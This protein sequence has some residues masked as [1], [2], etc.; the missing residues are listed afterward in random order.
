ML[1]REFPDAGIHVATDVAS[2]AAALTL[3]DIDAIVLEPDLQWVDG[4]ALRALVAGHWP[5]AALIVFGHEQDLLSRCLAPGVVADALARKSSAGFMALPDILRG[6][7]ARRGPAGTK[8]PGGDWLADLPVPACLVADDG[9]VVDANPEFLAVAGAVAAP[10]SAFIGLLDSAAV[11]TWQQFRAGSDATCSLGLRLAGTDA[12]ARLRRRREAGGF[13]VSLADSRAPAAAPAPADSGRA[14]AEEISDVAMMFSHDLKAPVQQIV[15]LLHQAEVDSTGN[16]DRQRL[17]GKAGDC[18]R[19]VGE[20]IDA[21]LQYL[22]VTTRTGA[23]GLVDLNE[24]LASALATL[25]PV[26]DDTD[27]DIIAHPLPSIVGDEIQLQHLFQN[28]LGN[29]IKFHGQE[30]P[31]VEITA[32][33]SGRHW[34]ISFMDNGIGIDAAFRDSVFEMGRRLHT[35]DEYPGTGIGLTLCRRIAARHGGSIHIDAGRDGGTTVI[36]ELPR[37]PA[38]VRRLV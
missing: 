29:A 33:E 37:A 35:P 38:G 15:R 27:A 8:G 19:R 20:M 10:G 28:I 18:A 6:A 17:L 34:V 14:A 32:R 23:P 24:S 1:A 16:L 7:L 3:P 2:L 25:R 9:I 36:V 31:R 22:S 5:G 30:R 26:I 13:V 4:E 12:N 21:M 11:A